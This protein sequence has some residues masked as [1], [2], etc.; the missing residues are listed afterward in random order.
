MKAAIAIDWSSRVVYSIEE[1]LDNIEVS[2]FEDWLN[3]NYES[4]EVWDFDEEKR[5][6][7]LNEYEEYV[8]DEK[9]RTLAY[10][11]EIM[12]IDV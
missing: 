1:A 10:D 6:Q 8:N 7:I 3:D 5:K 2:T 9:E 12:T 4:S 11:Y